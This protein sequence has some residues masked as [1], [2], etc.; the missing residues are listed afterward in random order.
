VNGPDLL[1]AGAGPAG[2]ATAIRAA[3]A[4]LSV[5]V[6]EPRST[7]IDKACGEG[8]AHSAVEYLG[9][10]GVELV[11]R[12]FHGIRYL[13][14][15]HR[16]D[17]RFAA[18]PGLGVRRTTLQAALSS[19][20][21]ELGVEVVRA[22]VGPIT[23]SLTSVTAAGITARYLAAA[24]GLHSPIRRQ[25]AL[26]SPAS[27]DV[28]RGLRQ[29]FSVAPWTDLVEVYWSRLGEAYVTPVADDVVDVA[30]LTSARGTFDSHLEAFPDLKRRL[31]G[32]PAASAVMG[33]GP[34]RQR[35]RRRV[36]GR[37]LLVGD[38][39]GY[40]DALTGEG[41]AVALRTSAELVECVRRDEPAS[42]EAAWRRVSRECRLL[43]GSLLWARNRS[44]LGPR[45]V[46]AAARLP[47]VY[48]AIVNRLS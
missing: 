11:G 13:D 38:A 37:V 5:V 41:I 43:T 34:L 1:V 3:L 21:A 22:R 46:P 19:R 48:A 15:A 17:A 9:R 29:H 26:C 24:D 20:L 40:V 7:P 2:A 44:L 47:G 31:R 39:A 12:P 32:A 14:S 18:G 6:V 36:A 42:Y 45:I 23:Q 27:S 25:L 16:V 8:I 30:I 10:L 28:R 33:A 4:G 35:V